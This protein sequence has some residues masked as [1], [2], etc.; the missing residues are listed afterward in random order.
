LTC[1]IPAVHSPSS[2]ALPMT[3]TIQETCSSPAS[4]GVSPQSASPLRRLV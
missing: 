1:R 2:S 3:Q 4:T